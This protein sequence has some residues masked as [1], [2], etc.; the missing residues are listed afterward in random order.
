MI[1]IAWKLLVWHSHHFRI[2]VHV[3]PKR[4][5][6]QALAFLLMCVLAWNAFDV[7]AS[8]QTVLKGSTEQ[9]PLTGEI[10]KSRGKIPKG[11]KNKAA[12]EALQAY[13]NQEYEEAIRLFFQAVEKEPA[14]PSLY[15]YLADCYIKTG[16][17][18]DAKYF[19]HK[20]ISVAPMSD[21]G[22]LALMAIEKI[23]NFNRKYSVTIKLPGNNSR[24]A[25]PAE[26]DT[27]A[28]TESTSSQGLIQSDESKTNINTSGQ[29]ILR[30]LPSQSTVNDDLFPIQSTQSHYLEQIAEDG[31]YVRWPEE[32]MPLKVYIQKDGVNAQYYPLAKQ[33][34]ETWVRASRQRITYVEVN[35]PEKA[36]IRVLWTASLGTK[37]VGGQGFMKEGSTRIRQSG[38]ELYQEVKVATL[39]FQRHPNEPQRMFH[40]LVHEFGHALGLRGHSDNP[41]D[42]MFATKTG[43]ENGQLSPRDI[44]TIQEL[45]SMEITP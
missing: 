30:Q 5:M 26:N 13:R 21:A 45:Y 6:T 17:Y 28:G 27:E 25:P 22:T 4:V 36:Q 18:G 10:N 1:H 33:A 7:E 38:Q 40:T 9:A 23:D 20:T 43:E 3:P 12:W 19:Y 2:A 29:K 24:T 31:I 11:V 37:D 16:H 34:M 39:D 35:T 14:N 32:A 44:N 41:G 8:A 15:Y 42:V